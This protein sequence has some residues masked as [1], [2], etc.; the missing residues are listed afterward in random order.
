GQGTSGASMS[1]PGL[2][3]RNSLVIAVAG[4]SSRTLTLAPPTKNI[5]PS[6]R[7]YQSYFLTATAEKQFRAI[8]PNCPESPG[9]RGSTAPGGGAAGV[10]FAARAAA[11]Q[12]Q[13]PALRTRIALIALEP[14]EPHLALLAGRLGRASRHRRQRD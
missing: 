10:A 12:R 11:H 4:M 14:G 3:D 1:H 6:F 5:Q 7:L 13:L 9:R 2:P 8:F